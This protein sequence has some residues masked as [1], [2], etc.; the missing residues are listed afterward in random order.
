M[1]SAFCG[2]Y[3]SDRRPERPVPSAMLRTPVR[4][5][6]TGIAL[7]GSE[8]RMISEEMG[9]AR[10][11]WPKIPE[12]SIAACPTKTSSREPLLTRTRWRKGS[13][14]TRTISASSVRCTARGA[15]ARTPRRRSFSCAS[16][17]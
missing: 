11:T 6:A 13:R 10:D 3:G 14:S 12:A 7:S 5:T 1:T 4:F 2:R 15:L 17:S 9:P 8:I 16:E